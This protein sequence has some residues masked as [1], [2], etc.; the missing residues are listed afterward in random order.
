[1]G[2]RI[3]IIVHLPIAVDDSVKLLNAIA[4]IDPTVLIGGDAD[5]NW[6][7][8]VGPDDGAPR[9]IGDDDG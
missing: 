3:T 1:M 2:D 7:I 5:G 4:D 9:L 8:E 6:L